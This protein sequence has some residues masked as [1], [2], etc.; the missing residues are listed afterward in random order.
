MTKIYTRTLIG[1]KKGFYTSTLPVEI[2]EFQRKP[3]IRIM[4]VLGGIS[5]LSLL[6]RSYIGGVSGLF[7]YLA[8]LLSTILVI[9]HFY[10]LIVRVKHI[11]KILKSD[12]LDIHL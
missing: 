11:Y 6:G 12:E 7:L 4:R 5:L 9:Y 10:I 8:F 1:I 2:L 3:L